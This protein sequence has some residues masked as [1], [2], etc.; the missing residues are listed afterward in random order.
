MNGVITEKVHH[1]HHMQYVDV[2]IDELDVMVSRHETSPKTQELKHFL[3][4]Q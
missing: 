2:V 4:L 1:R 3:V